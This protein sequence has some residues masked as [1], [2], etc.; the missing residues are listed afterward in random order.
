PRPLRAGR[1]RATGRCRSRRSPSSLRASGT[2]RARSSGFGPRASSSG[3]R[4][5]GSTTGSSF[6]TDPASTSE[7]TESASEGSSLRRDE[8]RERL[9]GR[10]TRRAVDSKG[11]DHR[12]RIYIFRPLKC[13]PPAANVIARSLFI[14]LHTSHRTLDHHSTQGRTGTWERYRNIGEP[15]VNLSRPSPKGPP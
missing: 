7:G 8:D 15:G 13:C 1:T 4:L 11:G 14:P 6:P 3:P 10:G 2:T 9:S 12:H 5:W